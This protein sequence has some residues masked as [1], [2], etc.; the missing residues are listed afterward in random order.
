LQD[1][2]LSLKGS[3]G[4]VWTP[5]NFDR[6][7][8]G[9]VP[10]YQALAQSLNVPT[11][12][13]GI[14]LGIKSVQ[15]TLSRLGVDE[16]EVRPVPS[17][18]LGSFSL[19][20]YQVTQMYQTLTNSGRK[21]P[22]SALRVVKNQHGDVIYQSF[23]KAQQVVAEQAAWL[24]TFAMKKVVTEG[25][26]RYLNNTFS[27]YA[28]AGK[29]GT[30]NDG[31]DS[32][33]VGVDGRE[34]VTLWVGRDDNKQ[35][36]LTGSSGALRVYADYLQRR[37]PEVLTLPWPKGIRTLGYRT[38]DNGALSMDCRSDFKLPV[39]DESGKLL[40][41]CEAEAKSWIEKIF[42]W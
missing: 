20:P 37:E 3:A 22:L 41:K 4:S 1:K 19:T 6:K 25:S 28:L 29:T 24:T 9:E 12:S 21:V 40:A 16:N 5:R 13:L 8:R 42:P 14:S 35:A 32:W 7:F 33:F 23:P 11:V 10:L 38:L 39:W 36:N 34:V 15:S 2:P 27:R 17:M 30:S 26:G 31:R 18:F